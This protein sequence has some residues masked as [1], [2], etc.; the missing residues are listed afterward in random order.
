M[1]IKKPKE[2]V[3]KSP[4]PITQG[5]PVSIRSAKGK[6]IKAVVRNIKCEPNGS[7]QM[8]IHRE[9]DNVFIMTMRWED[10]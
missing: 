1:K 7:W 4:V 3:Y 6:N 8:D 5:W 9:S 2:V 10:I